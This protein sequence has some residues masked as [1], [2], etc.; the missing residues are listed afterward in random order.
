M[1]STGEIRKLESL[2]RVVLPVKMRELRELNPRDLAEVYVKDNGDIVIEKFH[3]DTKKSKNK[4]TGLVRRLD[5][6]GR[7]VI[8]KPTVK[9]QDLKEGDL[10]EFVSGEKGEI[11]LRKYYQ[12][13]VFCGNDKDTI[14]F[15][16][17]LICKKC[18][19]KIV[20]LVK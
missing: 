15:E 10:M 4:P 16:E 20:K 13:C 14:S 17:K 5:A 2:N 18:L 8:P 9:T 1:K 12:K 7:I 19:D 6:L 11:I 3:G